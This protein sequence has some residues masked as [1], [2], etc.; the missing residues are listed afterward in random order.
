[1]EYEVVI[2]DEVYAVLQWQRDDLPAVCVVNQALAPFEPKA[3]FAWHLSII[4]ECVELAE[5][6]MPTSEELIVMDRIGDEFDEGLKAG[7]NSLFLARITWAGTRQYL[8]RVYD[9]EVANRYLMDLIESGPTV[10]EFE[11]RMEHDEAWEHASYYLSH[12][13]AESCAPADP[14]RRG[15]I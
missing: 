13:K 9:P 10:R 1:V 11:F 5:H 8:Y 15:G 12:W 2:P 4:V 6:G 7:G 14:A 3:V